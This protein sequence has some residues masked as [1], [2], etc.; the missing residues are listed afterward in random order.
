MSIVGGHGGSFRKV[1]PQLSQAVESLKLICHSL[2][3]APE[4][5]WLSSAT[6]RSIERM[7]SEDVGGDTDSDMDD[8]YGTARRGIGM[9]DDDKNTIHHDVE[10]REMVDLQANTP[11]EETIH[12][13][14]GDNKYNVDDVSDDESVWESWSKRG[15]T[16]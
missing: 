1:N 8:D 9:Y 4:K 11:I 6:I 3:S 10:D 14:G 7:H 15:E 12:T 5:W 16:M 2:N 13:S